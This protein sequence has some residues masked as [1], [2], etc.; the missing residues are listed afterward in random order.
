MLYRVQLAWVGLKLTTLVVTGTHYIGSYISKYNTITTTMT[1]QCV[2]NKLSLTNGLQIQ[3]IQEYKIA[4]GKPTI[5]HHLLNN[6]TTC[7]CS[8]HV[9]NLMVSTSQFCEETTP[10]LVDSTFVSFHLVILK[11]MVEDFHFSTN[12]KHC[13]PSWMKCNVST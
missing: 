9:W 2:I 10:G 12:Q 13:W 5:A 8:N 7:V 11:K 4:F 6:L 3:E 1:H